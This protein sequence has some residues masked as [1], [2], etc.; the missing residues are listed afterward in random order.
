MQ[1]VAGIGDRAGFDRRDRRFNNLVPRHFDGGH[2]TLPS[3]SRAIRFYDHQKRVIRRVIA[4]GSTY[5]AHAVGAGKTYSIADALMEQKRL[6]LIAKPLLVVACLV[7]A[8]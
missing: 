2:L 6:G 3:T 8:P 7:A 5:I 4:A 1:L